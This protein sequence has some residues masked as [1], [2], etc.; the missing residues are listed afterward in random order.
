MTRRIIGI[1]LA[2]VGLL[3]ANPL[4]AANGTMAYNDGGH[5]PDAALDWNDPNNWVESQIGSGGMG[6]VY[7]AKQ[8]SMHRDVALKVLRD[9][10]SKDETYMKRF[11]Y[12]V[13]LMAAMEHPNMVRVFEGG[14]DNDHAF[15]SMEFIEGADLKK[16]LDAK[17]VFSEMEA[18]RIADQVASALSYAWKKD[19]MVHRDV[20]PANIMLLKDGTAKILDLGI[21]KKFTNDEDVFIT[22]SGVMVGS[23]SYMSPEQAMADEKI[24]FRADIYSLGVSIFQILTGRPPY[25]GKSAMEVVTQHFNASIPDIRSDRPDI[26]RKFS[27]LVKRMMA[28][29][30]DDRFDSWDDFRNELEDVRK[31]LVEKQ[32]N[33]QSPGVIS[34]LF[35][36]VLPKAVLAVA[37]LLVLTLVLIIVLPGS[38]S[39]SLHH[40]PDTQEESFMDSDFSALPS[41]ETNDEYDARFR[42]LY[43]EFRARFDK[44]C[45]E[46]IANKDYS[47][48]LKYC[49]NPPIFNEFRE[50][51]DFAGRFSTEI[52]PLIDEKKAFFEA[53]ERET[54]NGFGD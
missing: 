17:H 46:F 8:I 11:F 52:Q 30:P 32:K 36:G 5:T 24:D 47:G 19:R 39:S 12:E 6:M 34:K 7:R 31:N 48:G 51:G 13:R 35:Q 50:G 53:K 27:H 22:N 18:I 20:K 26:S 38:R 15:F 29:E 40:A 14:I 4:F 41:F 42:R 1:A 16:M 2:A 43:N 44:K 54:R 37:F 23:P 21:S 10:L 49:S 9:N 25:S 45:D 33:A 3:V 28:K